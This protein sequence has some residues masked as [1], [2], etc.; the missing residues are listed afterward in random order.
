ME[1]TAAAY[2]LRPRYFVARENGAVLGAAA[3]LKIAG[4][5]A[6]VPVAW[7]ERGPA[8][9]DVAA[10]G[11]VLQ[12]LHRASRR[13]GNIYLRAMPYFANDDRGETESVLHRERFRNVQK[14]TGSHAATL[15]VAVSGLSDEQILEGSDRKKLRQELRNAAK[16]GAT[17][18]RGGSGDVDVLAKLYGDLMIAQGQKSRPMRWWQALGERVGAEPGRYG[19]FLCE[20]AGAP[21]AATLAIRCGA[22]ASYVM[23]AAAPGKL[24]FSKSALSVFE[25]IRWARDAGCVEFDMGGIPI[26]EDAD[27]KR[28]AIARFKHD[29]A[30]EP[31]ALVREHARW[32]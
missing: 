7:V 9:R 11:P 18:R 8:V 13:H 32:F 6:V 30:K 14:P 21:L 20:H 23:G 24:P 31:V 25:A 27:E 4:L 22:R 16:A 12:A 29:F 3:V 15:R 17:V 2:P 19:L 5:G 10:L 28:V 26:P 1:L